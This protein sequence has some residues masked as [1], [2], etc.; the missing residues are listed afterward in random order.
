VRNS[1]SST[2]VLPPPITAISLPRKKNLQKRLFENPKIEVLWD[3]AV[4]EVLGEGE[5]K[6]VT[7]LRV[8]HVAS[9]ASRELPVHGVF[10]AIGHAPAT[11][12]VQG[13]L[14][15]HH[16]AYVSVRSGS[17]ETSVPGVFAAGDVTDHV[18]RQAVTSAGM[19]CMA[20]LDAERFLAEQPRRETETEIDRSEN[21]GAAA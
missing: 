2:A 9:G 11:E 14:E 15:M 17:T 13:Q 19:G 18:Y 16:G 7:G 20:A 3:H 4:D 10:V 6:G 5:P 1:A 8:K 21:A 12:L